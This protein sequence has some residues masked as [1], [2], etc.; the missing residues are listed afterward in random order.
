MLITEYV[1]PSAYR[2][3]DAVSFDIILS[4][5]DLL[6]SFEIDEEYS[7][8]SEHAEDDINEERDTSKSGVMTFD[9]SLTNGR[10]G[11]VVFS[12]VF[13]LRDDDCKSGFHLVP[14][15]D[16]ICARFFIY[17]CEMLIC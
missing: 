5:S 15:P 10:V 9:S 11:F 6:E 1:A 4:A 13:N 3:A 7:G 8:G 12:R 17:Q 14:F 16:F 2:F